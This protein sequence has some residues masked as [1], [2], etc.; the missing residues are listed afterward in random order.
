MTDQTMPMASRQ[1]TWRQAGIAIGIG[2]LAICL[3]GYEAIVLASYQWFNNNAYTYCLL[4]PL[5]SGWLLYERRAEIAQ[6]TPTPMPWA[7]TLMLGPIAAYA[8]ADFLDI[9]EGMQFA[10][11]AAMQ[12]VFLTVLGW[13][14]YRK[15]AF[16]LNYLWLIVPTGSWLIPT[17]QDWA[18]YWSVLM[19]RWSEIPTFVTGYL[20]EVPTG[21]YLVAPGCAGLN[22]LLVAIALSFLFAYLT[23]RSWIAWTLTIVISIAVAIV[24]NWIRVYG[25]IFIAHITDSQAEIVE[26]HLLYGWF[27]FAAVMFILM[28]I[29][30]RFRGKDEPSPGAAA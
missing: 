21:K 22:F 14:V 6:L 12:V 25:I 27:Y 29:G 7:A 5:I 11:V 9:N 4:I 23:Y 1:L 17:L 26:D 30:L 13:P 8:V 10:M 3:L 15:L 2:V 18:T 24:S 19:L 28:S 20:I 16:P